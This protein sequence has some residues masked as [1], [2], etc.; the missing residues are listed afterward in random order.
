MFLEDVRVSRN[1]VGISFNIGLL[2]DTVQLKQIIFTDF[3]KDVVSIHWQII[4]AATCFLIF[5]SC[6]K[7]L[8]FL[9]KIVFLIFLFGFIFFSL[10]LNQDFPFKACW[11]TSKKWSWKIFRR[12]PCWSPCRNPWNT[13]GISGNI[14]EAISNFFP[15]SL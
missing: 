8:K 10:F 13:E 14:S 2:S 6:F 12:N 9:L 11:F 4:S 15:E 1:P 5:R 7:Y 3:H